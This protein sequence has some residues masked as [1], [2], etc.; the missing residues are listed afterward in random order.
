MF[1]K[2]RVIW[3]NSLVTYNIDTQYKLEKPLSDTILVYRKN[4]QILFIQINIHEVKEENN[5]VLDK[6]FS[7]IGINSKTQLSLPM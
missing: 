2:T 3:M 4:N 5:G 7:I 6:S 1:F